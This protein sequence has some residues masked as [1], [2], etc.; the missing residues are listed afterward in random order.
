M[1]RAIQFGRHDIL[2]D[3]EA[4]GLAVHAFTHPDPR[5]MIDGL[6]KC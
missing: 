3:G 4:I 5:A 6:V 2:A 1:A